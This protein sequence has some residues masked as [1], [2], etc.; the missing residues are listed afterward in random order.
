MPPMS[1]PVTTPNEVNPISTS[2]LRL[3]TYQYV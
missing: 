3:K 2:D 1:L